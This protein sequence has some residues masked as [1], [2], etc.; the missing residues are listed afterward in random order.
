MWLA[1]STDG[2]MHDTPTT[3]LFTVLIREVN[4]ANLRNRGD[5]M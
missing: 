1:S 4:I 2:I 5:I 3:M